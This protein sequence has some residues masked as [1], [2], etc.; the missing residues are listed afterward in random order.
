MKPPQKMVSPQR[1]DDFCFCD[2]NN[3]M[4]PVSQVFK[5]CAFLAVPEG[6]VGDRARF[7]VP[8]DFPGESMQEFDCAGTLA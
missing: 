1:L 5:F 7:D 6:A 4:P 2:T 8:L 3:K